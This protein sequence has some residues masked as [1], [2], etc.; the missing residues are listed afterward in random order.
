VGI[1]KKG[2]FMTVDQERMCRLLEEWLRETKEA[3]SESEK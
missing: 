3:K 1:R 2:G